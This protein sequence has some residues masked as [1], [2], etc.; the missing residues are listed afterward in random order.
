[1]TSLEPHRKRVRHYHEPGDVHELTF[2]CYRRLP[3]LTNNAWRMM[4]SRSI[5][6]ACRSVGCSLAAFV[7]MPEHVHLLVWGI[8]TKEDVST[9][10][11]K[12]KQPVSIQV[13]KDPE[14]AKSRLLPRLMVRE[15]PGK[16]VFRFWQ[17]GPGFDRN[18]FKT[19]AVQLSIDYIHANPVKRGLCVK[20]RDWRWSSARYYESDG[21]ELDELLPTITPLPAEFWT[22][23]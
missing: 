14:A 18:L 19:K 10:L 22:T 8:D 16:I 15:R 20:A 12:I 13:R 2:S 9:L 6:E 21:Q 23:G 3:L 5:D 1:M 4:L 11:A 7:H 17:E